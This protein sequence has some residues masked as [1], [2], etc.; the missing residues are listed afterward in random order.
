MREKERFGESGREERKAKRQAG[1]AE[2]VLESVLSKKIDKLD[3][4]NAGK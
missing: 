4:R 2:N 1:R 3:K